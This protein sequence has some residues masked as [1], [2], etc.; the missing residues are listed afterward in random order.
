MAQGLK[1]CSDSNELKDLK[2][3]LSLEMDFPEVEDDIESDVEAN[4][5][6]CEANKLYEYHEHV[7]KATKMDFHKNTDTDDNAIHVEDIPFMTDDSGQEEDECN[8]DEENNYEDDNLVSNV[9]HNCSITCFPFNEPTANKVAQISIPMSC[10]HGGLPEPK[11]KG[12]KKKKKKRGPI[13]SEHITNDTFLNIAQE[14]RKEKLTLFPDTTPT[15]DHLWSAKKKDIQNLMREGSEVMAAGLP[16]KA[17][18][19]YRAAV[20]ILNEFPYVNLDMTEMDVVLLKYSLCTSWV[21]ST[22]YEDI[23]HALEMLKELEASHSAKLPAVH[24]ALA[25]AYS[26]LNRPKPAQEHVENGLSFLRKGFDFCAYPWPG[27]NS[28]IKE[29]NHEDLE[30]SLK[31]ML[32]VCRAHHKPDA[33]CRHEN[34]LK[35]S[36]HI[37]P[38]E[39]IFYSDPDFAGFVTVICEQKCR[40]EY[41]INCWKDF[42]ESAQTVA[43]LRDKD[44]LGQPCLTTDCVSKAKQRSML[45]RIEIVGEDGQIKT[46]LDIEKKTADTVRGSKKIKKKKH[47]KHSENTAEKPKHR[48]VQASKERPKEKESDKKT[49]TEPAVDQELDLD[50]IEL[51]LNSLLERLEEQRSANFYVDPGRHFNPQLAYFGVQEI[52]DMTSFLPQSEFEKEGSGEKEFIYSYFYEYIRDEDEQKTIDIRKKWLDDDQL[53][54][55]MNKYVGDPDM[56]CDFLVESPRFAVIDDFMCL[57]ETIPITY[58]EV[59]TMLEESLSFLIS[60]GATSQ[61][62]STD[63]GDNIGAKAESLTSTGMYESDMDSQDGDGDDEDNDGDEEEDDETYEEDNDIEQNKDRQN[64][65]K[66]KVFTSDGNNAKT[67]E[68][69]KS[70]KLVEKQENNRSE[71]T[72]YNIE[73]KK[74]VTE[75]SIIVSKENDKDKEEEHCDLVKDGEKQKLYKTENASHKKLIETK[76]TMESAMSEKQNELELK[77]KYDL[78]LLNPHANEFLPPL[79]Q[80][81][82]ASLENE[83]VSAKE[84]I[85]ER[86]SSLPVLYTSSNVVYPAS[87]QNAIKWSTEDG[88]SV[89][90]WRIST[91]DFHDLPVM[92]PSTK[93]VTKDMAIQTDEGDDIQGLADRYLNQRDQALSVL[94]RMKHVCLELQKDLKKNK[95]LKAK[96]DEV[97]E[98]RDAIKEQSEISTTLLNAKVTSVEATNK[99]IREENAAELKMMQ[100][101]IESYQNQMEVQ[102][103]QIEKER[104]DNQSEV[105]RLRESLQIV[106]EDLQGK[107]NT[108]KQESEHIA[109]LQQKYSAVEHLRA[110]HCKEL[111][112]LNFSVT[113]SAVKMYIVQCQDMI[114]DMKRLLNFLTTISTPT[115]ANMSAWIGDWEKALEQAVTC[116][117]NLKEEYSVLLENLN[118]GMDLDQ[119]QFPQ[120]TM[121]F[122]SEPQKLLDIMERN[123]AKALLENITQQQQKKQQEVTRLVNPQLYYGSQIYQ[124]LTQPQTMWMKTNSKLDQTTIGPIQL[125]YQLHVRLQFPI[126]PT[127]QSLILKLKPSLPPN[128]SQASHLFLVNTL[129]LA[130]LLPTTCQIL[131][132]PPNLIHHIPWEEMNY[133]QPNMY[134]SMGATSQHAMMQPGLQGTMMAPVEAPAINNVQSLRGINLVLPSTSSSVV[135]PEN[136]GLVGKVDTPP[137]TPRSSAT[138]S[139]GQNSAHSD[140]ASEVRIAAESDNTSGRTSVTSLENVPVRPTTKLTE[141]NPKVQTGTKPSKQKVLSA[142]PGQPM[143]EASTVSSAALGKKQSVAARLESFELQSQVEGRQTVSAAS[144]TTGKTAE[145]NMTSPR[146]TAASVMA[147]PA[148][149][150]ASILAKSHSQDVLSDCISEVRKRNNNTLTGLFMPFIINQVEQELTKRKEGTGAM[151]LEKFGNSAWRTQPDNT[152][153]WDK[154]QDKDTPEEDCI[155]CMEPLGSDQQSSL[156]C[157][158]TFHTRCIKPWL[159]TQSVCPMCRVFTRMVDE[160]PP[161]A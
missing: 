117:K 131:P 145:K 20:D 70:E 58:C 69:N 138:P 155:I 114:V 110:Q 65:P 3:E 146:P 160:F 16:N 118:A 82:T 99:K 106:C 28:M 90:T 84:A 10:N 94:S 79:E 2:Q 158:H 86:K 64:T 1:Y 46:F 105:L 74:S 88:Q 91:A 140:Q 66:P 29:T 154:P 101:K 148:P 100:D 75:P 78:P 17:I 149:T 151:G 139:P 68:V 40:I 27:T 111:W 137:A 96:Y 24:Y 12:K 22:V 33:V 76:S 136:Q 153:K 123:L 109:I 127:V 41:H 35:I 144:S 80:Q 150:M 34:C 32:Q 42:K 152:V 77:P 56:I 161:L 104:K 83:I 4:K 21:R 63:N 108:Y 9:P 67:N 31:S 55:G 47:E 85:K 23:V 128:Q 36:T 26:K 125:F 38:S 134:V 81:V 98:E 11:Q 102:Q 13:E 62:L 132:S 53:F 113:S 19:K 159:R 121:E 60:G 37:L 126:P 72:I 52:K 49:K 129:T 124:T 59:K 97:V 112:N 73:S 130:L 50:E 116:Q 135:P 48:P 143:A 43:K 95:D 39:S 54:E 18:E 142:M 92:S 57:A 119:K 89:A 93:P 147:K 61:E 6:V 120:F 8:I 7:K 45:I 157:N 103:K 5:T 15:I 71:D 44:I 25:T 51:D 107:L 115:H 30:I 14:I 87:P 156:H 133:M 122:P 141:L